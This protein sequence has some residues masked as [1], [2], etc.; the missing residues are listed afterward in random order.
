MMH[1]MDTQIRTQSRPYGIYSGQS[2]TGTIFSFFFEAFGFPLSLSFYQYSMIFIIF[3]HDSFVEHSQKPYE[4]ALL[5]PAKKKG[6]GG[7]KKS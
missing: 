1:L 5:I 7:C 2:G 3:T 6:V 4:K